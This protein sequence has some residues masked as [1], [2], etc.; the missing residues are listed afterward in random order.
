[1]T[2]KRR[3]PRALLGTSFAL[4]LLVLAGCSA[5][6]TPTD[7]AALTPPSVEEWSWATTGWSLNTEADAPY[8]DRPPANLTSRDLDDTGLAIYYE[9]NS[10]KVRAD[11]PVVY[12]QY[13]I[14]ALIE[15][16]RTGQKQW[17]ERAA[18]QAEQLVTMHTERGDGWWYPYSFDWTYDDRTLTAPWWSGMAQGQALSLFSRLAQV[19][20]DEQWATAADHTWASFRQEP[21]ASEPWSTFIDDEHLWFE[22]YAGDQPPLMVLNGQIFAIFGLY[23][24]WRLTQD[25]EVARYVD[26]GATTVLSIM[27]EIRN[28][29]D[30]SYYCVQVDFCA[31][32]RWQDQKYHAIH[33]WQLNTLAKLTGDPQFS[34][35]ADQLESD[36]QP[37]A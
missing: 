22:E 31:R 15:Y 33:S 10:D 30:I 26:G 4:A 32:A 21:S 5:V 18:R 14:S 34:E 37:A 12:A 20:G 16:E 25:P 13:G 24:Y 6:P 8:M 1:M 29:G 19:T 11:H 17:L 28:A 3:A 9:R 23:D 36:W 27:P 7:T 35:W 2:R